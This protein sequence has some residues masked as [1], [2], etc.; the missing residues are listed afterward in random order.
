MTGACSQLQKLA[1]ELLLAMCS[2]DPKDGARRVVSELVLA[3]NWVLL[4]PSASIQQVKSKEAGDNEED[5]E[6]IAVL[7]LLSLTSVLA[8]IYGVRSQRRR[9][10]AVMVE[11]G[12][13]PALLR[14]L[15]WVD[16]V[17]SV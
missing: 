13:V 7:Q 12:V 6:N 8:M 4:R 1:V 16:F 9:F 10:C 2:G 3:T 17:S 11:C 15:Q 14:V 5:G